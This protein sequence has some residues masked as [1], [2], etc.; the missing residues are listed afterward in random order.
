MMKSTALLLLGALLLASSAAAADE[1]CADLGRRMSAAYAGFPQVES[2]SEQQLVTWR[3]S[4]ADDPPGG[5]GN[6]VRLCQAETQ[7]GQSVFYWL[8]AKDGG[9][10]SGYQKC[11]Q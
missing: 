2:G 5:P 6:V 10:E 9:E 7:D 1:T 8:K 3:A 4:C 11:I